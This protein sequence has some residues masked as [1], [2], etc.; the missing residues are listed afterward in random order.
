M[1][2]TRH[3]AF[4]A[5]SAGMKSLSALIPVGLIAFA[6]TACV[7]P[8]R[9]IPSDF[10]PAA[11]SGTIVL[12]RVEI[13]WADSGEGLWKNLETPGLQFLRGDRMQLAVEHE[14]TGR[15]YNIGAV[16]MGPLSD[17]YV[18]LPQG[19]YRLEQI[20]TSHLKFPVKATIDVPTVP[21]VYVGTLRFAG[22]RTSF[23]ERLLLTMARG[24]WTVE[25][26]SDAVVARFR[27]HY[28]RLTDPVVPAPVTF[29]A[30]RSPQARSQD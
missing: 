10:R 13:V 24:R 21:A 14:R 4:L 22:H 23:G 16:D 2:W 25:D 26:T 8:V 9:S 6:L 18:P 3:G 5:I 15:K 11:E 27:R 28:P 19:R 7:T 12:G 1:A 17:F 30:I 20:W 29:A